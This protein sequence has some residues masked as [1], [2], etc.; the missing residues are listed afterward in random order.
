MANTGKEE[1]RSKPTQAMLPFGKK[2]IRVGSGLNTG[3]VI[4]ALKKDR[5]HYA[6]IINKLKSFAEQDELVFEDGASIPWIRLENLN[7]ALFSCRVEPQVYQH[8]LELLGFLRVKTSYPRGWFLSDEPYPTDQILMISTDRLRRYARGLYQHRH[9]QLEEDGQD[10]LHWMPV[11]EIIQVLDRWVDNAEQVLA[12][13]VDKKYL[14]AR[15]E[16]F[17]AKEYYICQTQ[18]EGRKF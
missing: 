12:Q 6:D 17:P 18:D 5:S 13:L 2:G 16:G 10:T 11:S 4:I 3:R 1:K 14:V 7:G 15:G 9:C 8:K